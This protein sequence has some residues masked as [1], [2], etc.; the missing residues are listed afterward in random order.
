MRILRILE[1]GIAPSV[2]VR[3]PTVSE[4]LPLL[5][6]NRVQQNIMKREG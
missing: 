1:N 4:L 3:S 2:K 5:F 6:A